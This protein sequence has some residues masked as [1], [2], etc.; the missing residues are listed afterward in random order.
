M[1][2]DEL[3]FPT[4]LVDLQKE[5]IVLLRDQLWSVDSTKADTDKEDPYL[6]LAGSCFIYYGHEIGRSAMRLSVKRV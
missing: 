5:G 4:S 6:L 1:E 3:S 2:S